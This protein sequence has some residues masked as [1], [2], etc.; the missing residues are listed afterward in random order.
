MRRPVVYG[1]H[2]TSLMWKP[3][4]AAAF[5]FMHTRACTE[6]IQHPHKNRL[7]LLC[8][9]KGMSFLRGGP[10]LKSTYSTYWLLK[11]RVSEFTMC[12]LKEQGELCLFISLWN[13]CW[14]TMDQPTRLVGQREFSCDHIFNTHSSSCTSV[15]EPT[16]KSWSLTKISILSK[17][18]KSTCLCRCR[19]TTNRLHFVY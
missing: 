18:Y 2:V 11:L 10:A 5:E 8:W 7:S 16:I 14:I 3:E 12:I 4:K 9:S 13:V 1:W 19:S 17:V 6:M 15:I